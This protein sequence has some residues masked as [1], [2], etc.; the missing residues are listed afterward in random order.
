M[1]IRQL[2]VKTWSWASL[3]CQQFQFVC[4]LWKVNSGCEKAARPHVLLSSYPESI[5]SEWAVF[6][7]Y[8]VLCL[9]SL[10]HCMF[11]TKSH[12]GFLSFLCLYRSR[13]FDLPLVSFCLS[14]SIFLCLWSVFLPFVSFYYLYLSWPTG[15]NPPLFS[16]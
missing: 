11:F 7:S 14:F 3:Q 16:V 8:L 6:R 13:I 2:K 5:W 10:L 4:L 12:D 1:S 9:R 15:T